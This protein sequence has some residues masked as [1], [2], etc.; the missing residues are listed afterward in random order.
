MQRI[1]KLL[2]TSGAILCLAAVAF[3]AQPETT[4]RNL[5]DKGPV[6]ISGTVEKV[7]NEREFLLRDNSGT[8]EVKI[9]SDASAV[10]KQGD[11]VTV[12]GVVEKPLW[13]LDGQ[14][15]QCRQRAGT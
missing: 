12:N 8:V 7:R 9:A 4:V 11:S 2:A 15:Y 14:G 5:P 6:T 10:L 13:G 1:I 3:A